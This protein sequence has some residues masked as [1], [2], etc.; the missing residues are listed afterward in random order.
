MKKTKISGIIGI[1]LILSAVLLIA[2]TAFFGVFDANRKVNEFVDTLPGNEENIETPLPD[3][4][5]TTLPDTPDTPVTPDVTPSEPPTVAEA[6]KAISQR[7]PSTVSNAGT[8]GFPNNCW[9]SYNKDSDGND[10]DKC[11]PS[12]GNSASNLQGSGISAT[13]TYVTFKNT[14][15]RWIGSQ[16]RYATFKGSFTV[17]LSGKALN[18]ARAGLLNCTFGLEQKW[19]GGGLNQ[20]YTFKVGSKSVST[21][22]SGEPVS[23]NTSSIDVAAVS[24]SSSSFTVSFSATMGAKKNGNVSIGYDFWIQISFDKDTTKPNAYIYA[25]NSDGFSTVDP[26]SNYFRATDNAAGIKSVKCT[27]TPFGSSAKTSTKTINSDSLN[28]YYTIKYFFPSESNYFGTYT[29]SVTDNDGNTSSNATIKYYKANVS[30]NAD[31]GGSISNASAASNLAVGATYNISATVTANEGY[32]FIGWDAAGDGSPSDLGVGSYSNGKWTNDSDSFNVKA[33]SGS[34]TGNITYT[35]KFRKISDISWFSYTPNNSFVYAYDTSR[36]NLNSYLNETDDFVGNAFTVSLTYTGT[37][38]GG[39]A[40]DSSDQPKYAGKYRAVITVSKDSIDFAVIEANE[41]TITAKPIYLVPNLSSSS[42]YYDGSTDISIDSWVI[43]DDPAF[44]TADNSDGLTVPG[45]TGVNIRLSS[46]NAGTQ[47]IVSLVNSENVKISHTNKDILNS[48]SA[49]VVTGRAKFENNIIT[50]YTIN[51]LTVKITNMVIREKT[52]ANASKVYAGK[53][54][55]RTTALGDNVVAFV[56]T[57][58]DGAAEFNS[59][60]QYGAGTIGIGIKFDTNDLTKVPDGENLSVQLV[61]NQSSVPETDNTVYFTAPSFTGSAVGTKLKVGLPTTINNTSGN[62]MMSSTAEQVDDLEITKKPVSVSFS[63]N[64]TLTYDG[65]ATVSGNELTATLNGIIDGDNVGVTGYTGTL[66]DMNAGDGR[67]ITVS[68][69]TLSGTA[70]NNYSISN[71]SFTISGVTVGKRS[72]TVSTYSYSDPTKV[73]DGTVNAEKDKLSLSYSGHV[74]GEDENNEGKK[75]NGVGK[76]ITGFSVKYSSANAGDVNI[77]ITVTPHSNYAISQ[78]QYSVT[79]T[80]TAKPL[81]A[82]GIAL[83]LDNTS[84]VYSGD[85]YTPS[86]VTHTDVL[87]DG[88]KYTLVSGTDY[89]VSISPATAVGN[90]Y[91]A[92]VE[93]IGNYS[94]SVSLNYSVTAGDYTVSLDK[95][96]TITLPYGETLGGFGSYFIGNAVEN[97]RGNAVPGSWSLDSSG[98]TYNK[99]GLDI[100]AAGNHTIYAVFTVDDSVKD[101][102]KYAS[103]NIAVTLTVNK[104]DVTIT[105]DDMAYYY[106][107]VYDFNFGSE[108]V[109]DR[110]TG[111]GSWGDHYTVSGVLSG[112]EENLYDLTFGFA[113]SGDFDPEKGTLNGAGTYDGA[114][115]LTG[116]SSA[117]YIVTVEPGDVTINP[118]PVTL[119][120]VSGQY[121]YYGTAD[122]DLQYTLSTLES[123]L[124]GYTL[125]GNGEIEGSLLRT[126]GE[127]VDYYNFDGSGLSSDNY[128]LTVSINALISFRIIPLPITIVPGNT[129]IYFGATF[130][131]PSVDNGF[132][133]TAEID[134]AYAS[135]VMQSGNTLVSELAGTNTLTISFRTS[136]VQGSAAGEYPVTVEI[137]SSADENGINNFTF[138]LNAAGVYTIKALPVQITANAVGKQFADVDPGT[139][140]YTATILNGIQT[141]ESFNL[142][143]AL[144]GNLARDPGENVG[145]YAW[146]IGTLTAEANPSFEITYDLSSAKFTVSRRNIALQVSNIN[147]IVYGESIPAILG[148]DGAGDGINSGEWSLAPG[149]TY[150]GTGFNTALYPDLDFTIVGG[151]KIVLTEGDFDSDGFLGTKRDEDGNAIAYD[152]A[153]DS[154]LAEYLSADSDKNYFVTGIT[155]LSK[156]FYV[157]PVKAVVY[158]DPT[159]SATFTFGTTTAEINTALAGIYL[160]KDNRS[161]SLPLDPDEFTGLPVLATTDGVAFADTYP[162]VGK[163]VMNV[164]NIEHINGGYDVELLPDQYITVTAK[165]LTVTVTGGNTHEYGAATDSVIKYTLTGEVDGYRV[166]GAA[167]SRDGAS[168]TFSKKMSA[169]SYVITYGTLTNGNFPNYNFVFGATYY[170]TITPRTITVVPIAASSVYGDPEK[171]ISYETYYNYGTENQSAGLLNSDRLGGVLKR[172][173]SDNINVGEYAIERGT[174]NV[175]GV[176]GYNANYS[177]TVMGGVYYSITR[178]AIQIFADTASS[179]AFGLTFYDPAVKGHRLNITISSAGNFDVGLLN[180]SADIEISPEQ[181][182]A[183]NNVMLPGSYRIVQGTLTNENNPNFNITFVP[184]T[185]YYVVAKASVTYYVNSVEFNYGQFDY[186]G[187][188]LFNT[189]EFAAAVYVG[190][191]VQSGV[192]NEYFGDFTGDISL[193]LQNADTGRL[194]AGN[195]GYSYEYLDTAYL[196]GQSFE[197]EYYVVNIS[198]A[199]NALNVNAAPVTVSVQLDGET[200]S[201]N[202]NNV[203]SYNAAE[204]VI[205]LTYNGVIDGDDFAAQETVTVAFENA[206]AYA[207][208]NGISAVGKYVVSVYVITDERNYYISGKGA[209][210]F[211]TLDI[212]VEIAKA[213]LS[214]SV[215][216]LPETSFEKV[217]GSADPDFTAAVPGVGGESVTIAFVRQSGEDVGEYSFVSVNVGTEFAENYNA[218]LSGSEKAFAVTP[219]KISADPDVLLADRLTKTYGDADPDFAAYAD[220][221]NGESVAVTFVRTSGEDAGEYQIASVTTE[222]GNYTVTVTAA[223]TFTVTPKAATVTADNKSAI[224][225]GNDFSKT[226][227]GLTYTVDGFINNDAPVGALAIASPAVNAGE[228]TIYAETAFEN[229][230]YE[231]TFVPGTFTIE[232][233]QITVTSS[234]MSGV[235]FLFDPELEYFYAADSFTYTVENIAD[236]EVLNGSLGDL[237][238]Q[239][240]YGIAIP[241]GTLT[242]ENNPNYTIT[243]IAGT[244]DVDKIT[245][246]ITPAAASSFYGEADTVIKYSVAREDGKALPENFRLNGA[247]SYA[248][249]SHTAFADVGNYVVTLGNLSEENPDYIIEFAEGAENVVY[250][251]VQRPVTLTIDDAETVY[252]EALKELTMVIGGMGLATGETD[253]AVTLQKSDP[254]NR[255]VGEYVIYLADGYDTDNPNYAITVNEGK[256]TIV[257]RPI[258]V[259]LLDQAADWNKDG[260]YTVDQKAYDVIEGNVVSGDDL[261][262]VISSEIGKQKRKYP[263]T[264]VSTNPNYAVTFNDDAT[265][266]VRKFRADIEVP[267]LTLEFIYSGEAFSIAA[268]LNSGAEIVYTWE[269]GG[270]IYHDNA[271]VEVGRYVVTLS[272]GETEDYYAPE[273]VTVNLTIKRETLITEESGIEIVVDN[274]GG[275]NPEVE[276]E[277]EKMDQNDKDLNEVISG[278]ETIVRAFNITTSDESSDETTTITV[279]VP[280]ALKDLETVKVLVKQDGVYSVRMLNVDNGYVTIE[281]A[282]SVSAFAFVKE[283]A[284]VN[285]LMIILIGGAALIIIVSTVMFMLKKR[286]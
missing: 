280:E 103:K 42:K 213:E 98:I 12:Y 175:Q 100:Y 259:H 256:Y 23:L 191:L 161:D 190:G 70:A 246:L 144:K 180:G 222:N 41:F 31:T 26:G 210:S 39:T 192:G 141:D 250:T 261:G 21:N 60:T 203:Y 64:T 123:T 118:L 135:D 152:L 52:A 111:M 221:V 110:V 153:A 102:F 262:I 233:R 157:E 106:A 177:V 196:P 80:I 148:T 84:F 201:E 195:Y 75:N 96:A 27:F 99:D 136:A 170:Y 255:D 282:E 128:A 105:V 137:C 257:P 164:S 183:A 228:Y 104:A 22:S 127:S 143:T 215:D 53:V 204:R 8:Y 3:E 58:L 125:N 140:Y 45:T 197:T 156:A 211:N 59:L 10:C 71:T 260:I 36:T 216:A 206:A 236:G 165:T 34:V 146:N 149:N 198:G 154:V 120:P 247:L 219:A 176:N 209:S 150:Y 117:N 271:F 181:Y 116:Y 86:L 244:I 2:L 88:S 171:V 134:P 167:L 226:Y 95:A 122:P 48:Y 79:A 138:D 251:V 286:G 4:P 30:F 133:F 217:Y 218:V 166:T 229:D 227:S 202:G 268:T 107:G 25:S 38:D 56:Y 173:D 169:G 248:K 235:E 263:I 158:I 205:S 147:G 139:A 243:Y 168:D 189:P 281:A 49:T 93:G 220:G 7:L 13:Y 90:N 94:G 214:V 65:S 160:I 20:S 234:P 124:H 108:Y 54:Y 163:Y 109:V 83:A 212:N 132:S 184:R 57:S 11:N 249:I 130:V 231:I 253:F 155:G 238:M 224:Y 72:V 97:Q 200:L 187:N 207:V 131:S 278:N 68:D 115:T 77:I 252:G 78:T 264:A 18:Y 242:D 274:E 28:A 199:N 270:T 67:T 92:V 50:T 188:D 82:S 5:E 179:H 81:N 159:K 76:I 272:A 279:R 266:E 267:S 19:S 62:Y 33:P 232:R 74:K 9:T 40:Y 101:N 151:L 285:Y 284:S 121:K 44:K 239:A 162:K 17:N 174:L 89:S 275:F 240:G 237:R 193:Y 126:S 69:Y 114:I 43:Y 172:A 1:A 185:P 37:T 225:D 208:T 145:T 269:F 186:D 283:E 87:G 66:N 35:A 265:F 47:N 61:Q 194:N 85:P 223:A 129:E 241:Q 63:L 46:K 15:D 14:H 73:Y 29:F 91:Y 276:L 16:D 182:S 258:T 142:T 119:T 32:Y 277:V 230:N 273:N 254:D 55:D 178:K 112:D 6:A 51:K 113:A 245:L 24:S